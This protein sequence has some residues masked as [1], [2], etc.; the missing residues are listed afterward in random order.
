MTPIQQLEDK[1]ANLPKEVEALR[2]DQ[3][4]RLAKLAE[5]LG[6]EFEAT[7]HSHLTNTMSDIACALGEEFDRVHAERA[8]PFELSL[9]EL[10]QNQDRIAAVVQ[11]LQQE[12]EVKQQMPDLGTEK[13]EAERELC[14]ADVESLLDANSTF[15]DELRQ[16]FKNLA[17]VVEDLLHRQVAL[18]SELEVVRRDCAGPR[19]TDPRIVS[20]PQGSIQRSPVS[21]RIA[22]PV[23]SQEST[24]DSKREP[25]SKGSPG[26]VSESEAVSNL[27]SDLDRE[28]S[29][30]GATHWCDSPT[31]VASNA[32]IE[33]L[34]ILRTENHVKMEA[35]AAALGEEFESIH[36]NNLS[37][38][39]CF[40]GEEFDKVHG[41]L[42]GSVAELQQNQ[43]RLASVVEGML[44]RQDNDKQRASSLDEVKPQQIENISG[45]IE[46]LVE[47]QATLFSELEALRN[48]R[49]EPPPLEKSS[50]PDAAPST[51]AVR[52]LP[53]EIEALRSDNHAK[54]AA[55]AE[56][57]GEE[58][59][60]MVPVH[61]GDMASALGEEFDKLY[62][63][64]HRLLHGGLLELQQNQ[65]KLAAI[66]FRQE[67]VASTMDPNDPEA[68][69]KN[70]KA[71]SDYE[72]VCC[73]VRSEID[74]KL[75][76]L[77]EQ[78]SSSIEICNPVG[79]SVD[80]EQ[81]YAAQREQILSAVQEN[82]KA[83]HASHEAQFEKL[84][85]MARNQAEMFDE[86]RQRHDELQKMEALPP[87][88]QLNVAGGPSSFSFSL[89][90]DGPQ[91]SLQRSVQAAEG[92]AP[93]LRQQAAL[94]QV[95]DDELRRARLAL[96]GMPTFG[97]PDPQVSKVRRDTEAWDAPDTIA[98]GDF[99]DNA[100]P[101][102]SRFCAVPVPGLRSQASEVATASTASASATAPASGAASASSAAA[103]TS[104]APLPPVATLPSSLPATIVD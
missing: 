53:E 6:E 33:A 73:F 52:C 102:S 12:R 20:S 86:I 71:R 51:I 24:S 42:E 63:E 58:F 31:G 32:P 99:D 66:V 101:L 34:D 49:L 8:Q 74:Q 41:P 79:S 48:T 97:M 22:D 75:E 76:S 27:A 91:E 2:N 61:L 39:A 13:S 54:L 47:S 7:H 62:G 65:A 38:L 26:A 5:A 19:I 57:L 104:V 36:I 40:L 44:E 43:T 93:P 78:L 1:L 60:A 55:M 10:Q 100:P 69:S 85:L 17:S 16:N 25:Y 59:E 30:A 90:Q 81:L 67:H 72:S 94:Q 11:D 56:A 95:M 92:P 64:K 9:A 15:V 45:A 50:E 46:R 88:A 82:S 35:M 28:L 98:P 37:D 87:K 96:E 18:A 89:P 3:N 29:R 77:R 84:F 4:I 80:G 103:G 68:A 21:T 83:A 23:T 70:K 14:V